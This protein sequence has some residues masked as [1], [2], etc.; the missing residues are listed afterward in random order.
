MEDSEF[1]EVGIDNS[2]GID[3]KVENGV[4]KTSRAVYLTA[5]QEDIYTIAQ[6]N[7]PLNED[8]TFQNKRGLARQ[9]GG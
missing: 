4:V 2:T 3:W 1:E 5:A 7:A 9:D 8:G 6:A